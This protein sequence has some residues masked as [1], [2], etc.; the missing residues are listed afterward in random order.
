MARK[1]R[2]DS[3]TAQ[4]EKTQKLKEGIESP[5]ILND[6]ETLIFDG[7][8]EGLP[9]DTWGPHRVRLASTLAKQTFKL[10]QTMMEVDEEGLVIYNPRGNPISNPKQSAVMQ[11]TNSIQSLTRTL[12][13]SASQRGL[14]ETKTKSAKK[15]EAELRESI[16]NS[17]NV[18]SLLG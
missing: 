6:E 13:L 1:K 10:E 15:T 17:G 5:L 16:K 9:I 12:G 2:S 4:V 14:S 7:I 8:I 18:K 3:V 11:L